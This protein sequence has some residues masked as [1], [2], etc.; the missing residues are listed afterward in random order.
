MADA[1]PKP[2]DEFFI[3]YL[4]PPPGLKKFTVSITMGLV[5]A[6]GLVAALVAA[7]QEPVEAG[8]YEF[9]VIRDFEGVLVETPLPMIHLSDQNYA[10][11][12]SLPIVGPGKTGLPK[13]AEGLHGQLISFKGSY[14]YAR[15]VAVVEMNQPGSITVLD[16]AVTMDMNPGPAFPLGQ[17]QL[18]GEIV[19]TKCFTGV[20]RPATGKVHRACAIRCLSGGVP[21][22]FLVRD[23]NN[24]QTVFFLAGQ[25]SDPLEFDLQWTGRPVLVSGALEMQGGVPIIRVADMKLLS[26]PSE[27]RHSS[28][29]IP[30]TDPT[31]DAH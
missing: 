22:G 16:Q 30:E 15:N 9:G 27:I 2:G 23:F 3:G 5:L 4:A 7:N 19:D 6:M 18:M 20:M 10:A 12:L 1:P 21:A 28:T 25:G 11:G 14:A 31:G 13:Q 26:S 8:K 24:N 17:V 29:Y